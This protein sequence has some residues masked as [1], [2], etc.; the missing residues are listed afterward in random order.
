[1][2]QQAFVLRISPSGVDRVPEALE[3]DQI[4]IGWAKAA[5][6]LN[7]SLSWEQFR[8]VIHT[9]H[10]RDETIYAELDRPQVTCGALSEK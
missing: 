5:G 1:M 3:S 7:T 2:K 9:T 8:Q 6:L 4:I 10:Y